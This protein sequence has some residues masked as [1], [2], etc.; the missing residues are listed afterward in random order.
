VENF[1]VQNLVL[2]GR[3]KLPAKFDISVMKID[4]DFQVRKL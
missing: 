2:D 3:G 1:Q 4:R